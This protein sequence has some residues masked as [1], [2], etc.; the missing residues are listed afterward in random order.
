MVDELAAR[1][2]GAAPLG[3]LGVVAGA[4]IEPG[5]LHFGE[6]NGPILAPGVGA[7]G[8]TAEA[9]RRL[10]GDSGPTCCPA[11]RARCCARGP[12]VDALRGAVGAL[13]DDFAFLRA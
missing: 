2:S 3:S 12:D 9:V 8:G 5:V 1:N 10:F 7:Q 13:I 11:S 4:T 6:L